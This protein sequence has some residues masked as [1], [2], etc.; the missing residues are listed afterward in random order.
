MVKYLMLMIVLCSCTNDFDTIE[1]KKSNAKIM[2]VFDEKES[3]LDGT[4]YIYDL[5]SNLVQSMYVNEK[6]AIFT[7]NIQYG[8]SIYLESNTYIFKLENNN[9]HSIF[10][11]SINGD[12]TLNWQ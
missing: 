4:V 10:S 2:Y 11:Q 8:F 3:P 5:D 9:K 7:E 1:P 12:F 6:E